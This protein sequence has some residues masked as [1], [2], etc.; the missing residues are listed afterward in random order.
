MGIHSR[1][2][3]T[4]ASLLVFLISISNLEK[5]VYEI[6]SEWG[7]NLRNSRDRYRHVYIFLI[8]KKKE[9][10]F[11]KCLSVRPCA[12]VMYTKTQERF[13]V[14]KVYTGNRNCQNFDPNARRLTKLEPNEIFNDFAISREPFDEIDSNFFYFKGMD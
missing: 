12:K 6:W 11:E 7:W 13:F 4:I 5:K 1:A 3:P 14:W 8:S 9:N 10:F 2:R